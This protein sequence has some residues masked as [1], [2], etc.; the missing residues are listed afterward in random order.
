[1]PHS[2]YHYAEAYLDGVVDWVE[3]REDGGWEVGIRYTTDGGT[4]YVGDARCRPGDRVRLTFRSVQSAPGRMFET[5]AE[6]T[7]LSGATP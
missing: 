1:M 6:L 5:T 2:G 3:P 4:T 7:V